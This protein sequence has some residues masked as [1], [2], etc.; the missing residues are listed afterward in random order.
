MPSMITLT[1]TTSDDRE[2]SCDVPVE[3]LCDYGHEVLIL[4]VEETDEVLLINEIMVDGEQVA[5]IAT[6]DYARD[7]IGLQFFNTM[8]SV[9][10]LM[11]IMCNLVQYHDEREV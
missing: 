3:G 8:P 7:F 6:I 4:G 5:A 11:S 9:D 1:L 2:I 10:A